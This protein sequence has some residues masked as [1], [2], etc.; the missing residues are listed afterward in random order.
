MIYFKTTD[1]VNYII[2][3]DT[4][5]NGHCRLTSSPEL[6][7]YGSLAFQIGAPI[8][9]PYASA[10]NELLPNVFTFHQFHV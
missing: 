9:S 4:K 8:G 7:E 10:F 3:E 5:A 1:I 6:K 2:R